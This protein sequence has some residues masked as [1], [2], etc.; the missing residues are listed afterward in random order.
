MRYFFHLQTDSAYERDEEGSELEDLNA[1]YLEAFEAA[2]QLSID[3]IRQNL[4]P[5]RYRFEI[6][7]AKD[8]VLM[9]LPFGEVLG[10]RVSLGDVKEVHTRGREL[11]HD[12][13]NEI[14]KSR[15]ELNTL[16]VALK[17]IC[18]FLE[19]APQAAAAHAVR[20]AE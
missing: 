6:C 8:N 19:V 14:V 18:S 20:G 4:R 7:D 3:L 13:Q 1:A 10:N 9:N 11:V 2:Q 5:A 12:V 16:F 17:K 15:A